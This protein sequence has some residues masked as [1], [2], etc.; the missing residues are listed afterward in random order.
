MIFSLNDHM[1][2]QIMLGTRPRMVHLPSPFQEFL[3][4]WPTLGQFSY[5]KYVIIIIIIIKT[6][7]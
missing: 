6:L 5:S 1:G 3:V 2:P 7:A 4:E